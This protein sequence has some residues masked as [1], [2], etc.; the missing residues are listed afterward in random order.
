M[1]TSVFCYGVKENAGHVPRSALGIGRVRGIDSRGLGWG[2]DGKGRDKGR[3]TQLIRLEQEVS[4]YVGF[5]ELLWIGG[6]VSSLGSR[7]V[8]GWCS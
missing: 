4:G 5:D 6:I 7:V 1:K 2:G 3:G 8:R